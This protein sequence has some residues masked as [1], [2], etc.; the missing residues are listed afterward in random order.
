MQSR[1]R[2][3][4][5]AA[6]RRDA[7]RKQKLVPKVKSLSELKMK[8]KGDPRYDKLMRVGASNLGGGEEVRISSEAAYRWLELNAQET[9]E[10]GVV[11][12]V[13]FCRDLI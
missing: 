8:A 2:Q 1:T 11:V 13:N 5:E 6:M 10:K 12:E 9:S 7:E 4:T 3:L